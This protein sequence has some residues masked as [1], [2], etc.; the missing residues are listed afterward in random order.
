M[1]DSMAKEPGRRGCEVPKRADHPASSRSPEAIVTRAMSPSVSAARRSAGVKAL[2]ERL[3]A[4][5][6]RERVAHALRPGVGVEPFGIGRALFG[7]RQGGE[8]RRVTENRFGAPVRRHRRPQE[9]SCGG[10]R[11]GCDAPSRFAGCG[12]C[13]RYAGL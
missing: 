12:G 1:P 10:D 8:L 13:H 4:H 9:V 3:A 5:D 7:E 11:D 6:Q 2:Q